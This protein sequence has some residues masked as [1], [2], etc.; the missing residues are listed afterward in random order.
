MHS[1][2]TAI[3]FQQTLETKKKKLL[4]RNNTIAEIMNKNIFFKNGL[5]QIYQAYKN[6]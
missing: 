1:T 5:L 4:D 2:V 3:K 6:K